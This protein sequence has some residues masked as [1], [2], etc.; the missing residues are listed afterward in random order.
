MQY[1]VRLEDGRALLARRPAPEAPALAVGDRVRCTWTPDHARRFPA[2][3]AASLLATTDTIA[4][5]PDT[6]G[7]S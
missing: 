6:E 4:T 3:E 2:S 5:A 1:Q 7:A